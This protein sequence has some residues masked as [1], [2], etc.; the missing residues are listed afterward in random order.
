MATLLALSAPHVQPKK[1]AR[2]VVTTAGGRSLMAQVAAVWL[3]K[4]VGI[5]TPPT[6]AR[7]SFGN[8]SGRASKAA[9]PPKS[10]PFLGK[11]GLACYTE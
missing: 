11:S 10:A 6:A 9:R 5:T 7:P 1:V 2:S 8:S 4:P 3:A